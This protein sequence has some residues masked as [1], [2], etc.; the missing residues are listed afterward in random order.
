MHKLYCIMGRSASG[1]STLARKV[2]EHFKLSI[3]K[4]YTTRPIRPGENPDSSDHIFITEKDV[5]KYKEQ[6][7]AETEINGYLYFTTKEQLKSADIY[8][9]DPLGL[10]YLQK[11]VNTKEIKLVPIYIS[12][13]PLV[14]FHHAIKR[15]DNLTE[16]I[17]RFNAEDEQFAVFEHKLKLSQVECKVIKNNKK[18]DE[19][20]K[21]LIQYIEENRS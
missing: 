5:P 4:S 14:A 15:E 6:V 11:N 12:V 20:A 7:I 19:A 18:L 17:K 3:L 21:C 1:K 2:A 16:W 10:D 8:V 9:I 13:N